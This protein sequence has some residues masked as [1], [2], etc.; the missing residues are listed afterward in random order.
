MDILLMVLVGVAIIALGALV[1]VFVKARGT[2]QHLD[3]TLA[4]VTAAIADLHVQIT[5]LASKAQVTIDAV[6]AEL[7][8]VDEIITTVEQATKRVGRTSDAVSGL[9][10]AP[11]GAVADLAGR[12]R[13]SFKGRR[14]EA[15]DSKKNESV[16][17]GGKQER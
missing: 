12:V 17:A 10:N 15:E 4:E 1:F 6:N 9:I 3:T 5:P 7:M 11:A 8:R 16:R 13:K 14:V 2:L